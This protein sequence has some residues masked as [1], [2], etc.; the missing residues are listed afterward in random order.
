MFVLYSLL[1]FVITIFPIILSQLLSFM[2]WLHVL[3][4]FPSIL[5]LLLNSFPLLNINSQHSLFHFPSIHSYPWHHYLPLFLVILSNFSPL[6]WCFLFLISCPFFSLTYGFLPLSH[7]LPS[8]P[9]SHLLTS[10]SLYLLLPPFTFHPYH[11]IPVSIPTIIHTLYFHLFQLR[12]PLPLLSYLPLSRCRLPRVCRPVVKASPVYTSASLLKD[13]SQ[14]AVCRGRIFN[15]QS[16][17]RPCDGGKQDGEEGGI[18]GVWGRN[19]GR[20]IRGDPN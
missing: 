19:W 3:V 11:S 10:V 6:V 4:P 18:E 16:L 17:G 5:Y 9:H 2:S 7:S 13:T 14:D 20:G 12:S 15:R 1:P 8:F